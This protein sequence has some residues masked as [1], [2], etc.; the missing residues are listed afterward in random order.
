MAE[1]DVDGGGWWAEVEH[2]REPL[3]RR[4]AERAADD[5]RRTVKIRGQAIA[6]TSARQLYQTSETPAPRVP[7][8]IVRRDRPRRSAPDRLGSNPDRIAAWA[9][10]F[11]LLMALIAAG[12][13]HGAVPS[14]AGRAGRPRPP[15]GHTRTGA[16][17]ALTRVVVVSRRRVSAGTG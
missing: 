3:E 13:A 17:P 10:V 6:G 11:G 7:D 9:V 5:P 2:L 14:T 8:A 1:I 16:A 4:R 12:T 15:F